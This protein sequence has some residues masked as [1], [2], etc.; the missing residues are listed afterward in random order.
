MPDMKELS[1]RQ[2]DVLRLLAEGRKNRDIA[3]E[4][5]LPLTTVTNDTYALYGVLGVDN[6][7]Q[8]ATW[9]YEHRAELEAA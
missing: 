8:A 1:P 7:V 9:F 6:R 2:R 5:G 3:R 4:L